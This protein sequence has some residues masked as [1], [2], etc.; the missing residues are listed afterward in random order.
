MP[1]DDAGLDDLV[2]VVNFLVADGIVVAL[3]GSWS[4][5]DAVGDLALFV[6]D[7]IAYLDSRFLEGNLDSRDH[8]KVQHRDF[9]PLH[10]TTHGQ[11]TC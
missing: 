7:M 8:M 10:R 1:I 9:A 5:E 3:P 2:L 4:R 11:P 6:S